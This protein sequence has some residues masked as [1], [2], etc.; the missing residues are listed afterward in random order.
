MKRAFRL[1]LLL[2]ALVGLFGGT[3]ANASVA[4]ANVAAMTAFGS[5]DCM[6][7]MS[8]HQKPGQS[9]CRNAALACVAA[10]GCAA[11]VYIVN[12]TETLTVSGAMFSLGYF[13][14]AIVLHGSKRI[15]EPRPPSTF[16]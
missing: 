8:N 15:P 11:S 7:M 2:G 6:T 1:F 4:P 14:R 12:D 9:P 16:G 5:A 10:V 3:A 13:P